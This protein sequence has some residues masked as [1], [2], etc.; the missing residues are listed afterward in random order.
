VRRPPQQRLRGRH[1]RAVRRIDPGAMKQV[2]ATALPTLRARLSREGTTDQAVDERLSAARAIALLGPHAAPALRDLRD[3]V[4]GSADPAPFVAAC[5][6]SGAPGQ[7]L[8]MATLDEPG[9]DRNTRRR[10]M[11]S[12]A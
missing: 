10:L 11:R 3:A 1:R 9:I 2:A 12:L 5:I 4:L 6:G 7:E 8:L